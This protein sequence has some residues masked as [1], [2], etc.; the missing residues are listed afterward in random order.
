MK[1]LSIAST[2]QSEKLLE[3]TS[4]NSSQIDQNET[5]NASD[6]EPLSP[7]LSKCEAVYGEPKTKKRKLKVDKK[8]R[9]F[10][11]DSQVPRWVA[12]GSCPVCKKVIKSKS[13]MKIHFYNVH[14]GEEFPEW[15]RDEYEKG[16]CCDILK[17]N[18]KPYA[19]QSFISHLIS[20]LP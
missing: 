14:H 2:N 8:F 18:G 10:L 1:D 11:P 19:Q 16:R 9:N 6:H 15:F 12:G 20:H 5:S 13:T 17:D 3:S 7:P 4:E